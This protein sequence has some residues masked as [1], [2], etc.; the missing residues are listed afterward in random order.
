MNC[1]QCG[2]PIPDERRVKGA[3]T[4]SPEC[5]RERANA[6]RRSQELPGSPACLVCGG[7]V[8]EDRRRKGAVTCSPECSGA[9]KLDIRRRHKEITRGSAVC[10]VC[11]E[12]VSDE[13]RRKGAVTCSPE[14]S[15]LRANSYRTRAG[16]GLSLG[17]CDDGCLLEELSRRGYHIHLPRDD[18]PETHRINTRRFHGDKIVLGLVSD[19]HLCSRYQQL[20][21]L[22][23]TYRLFA[24]RGINTVI[25]AGDLVDGQGVYNGQQYEMFLFGFDAQRDYAVEHYPREEGITTYVIEG[26]HDYSW[27]KLAGASILEAVARERD[28]L[29]CLGALGAYLAIGDI[30]IYIVHPDGGGAYALSYRP[31]K[32]VEQFSPENKPHVLIAGHWHRVVYMPGYRNVEALTLPCF[33]AQT[34]FLVRKNLFPVVA[35][36]ILEIVPDER[37]LASTRVELLHYYTPIEGDY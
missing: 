13:R 12:P 8:S 34:P 22:R 17:E 14:C 21:H 6:R 37:G 7:E 23:T 29:V 25:H 16:A 35:G 27:R 4:C 24:E 2:K 28:D 10:L 33:Q 26:N 32:M 9:R 18:E 30:R 15:R 31:Q 1:A 5:S 3:I 11:G 19:T 20:T 36:A